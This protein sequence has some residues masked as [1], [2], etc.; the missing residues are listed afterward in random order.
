MEE[1][2]REN[3]KNTL[4][5]FR[6]AGITTFLLSADDESSSLSLA[7]KSNLIDENFEC[8]HFNFMNFESGS[9]FTKNF[10]SKI[11]NRLIG[12]S[13]MPESPLKNNKIFKLT[14]KKTFSQIQFSDDWNLYFVLINGET[15]DVINSTEYL[16]IHF[17]FIIYYAKSIVAYNLTPENKVKNLKKNL[18]Y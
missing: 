17:I 1:L 5:E 9:I 8:F 12:S 13:E 14:S 15:L 3:V 11:K 7:F 10:L 4:T 2:I 18:F 16:K 6:E